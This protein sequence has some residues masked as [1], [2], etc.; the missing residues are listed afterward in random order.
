MAGPS[1]DL[2]SRDLAAFWHPCS[3]M[4]D[5]QPFAPLPVVSA[6]GLRL[7]LADGREI[8]DGISSWWCKSF[9]HGH[10]RLRRALLEP[11]DALQPVLTAHTT[12]APPVRFCQLLRPAAHGPPPAAVGAAPPPRPRPAPFRHGVPCRN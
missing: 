5:Y 11:A 3:Q 12:R 9:G 4:R 1:N 2:I 10:P 8:L 7:R 6:R